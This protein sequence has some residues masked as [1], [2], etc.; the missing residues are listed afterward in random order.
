MKPDPKQP[1]PI[2]TRFAAE[3]AAARMSDVAVVFVGFGTDIAREVEDRTSLDLAADQ[4]EL[5]RQ[6]VTANPRTVVVLISGGPLA[7]AWIKDHVPAIL[8]AWYPGEQ[9]GTAIA[10]VLLGKVSPAGR[11]PLTFYRSTDQLP[12]MSDYEISHGRTYRYF[13]GDPLFAFGHGLSYTK[14]AYSNLAVSKSSGF[15]ASVIHVTVDV[16]NR[17]DMDGDEVVQL[18]F[19][20]ENGLA[21][22]PIR[23]LGAFARVFIAKGKTMTVKLEVPYAELKVYNEQQKEFA[24]FPGILNLEVGGSS[25]DIQVKG[26]LMIEP[27]DVTEHK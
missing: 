11:L 9:S 15:D 12:P 13:T 1:I 25:S 7:V 3:V 19:H 27:A 10:D 14:F 8:E 24:L 17:G 16:S 2:A 4:Q 5:V 26:A 6:V 20:Q 18:Y 23:Q 22:R 21:E